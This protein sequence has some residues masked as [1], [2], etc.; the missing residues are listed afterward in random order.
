MQAANTRQRHTTKKKWKWQLSS[1]TKS[2][3]DF[4]SHVVQTQATHTWTYSYTDTHEHVRTCRPSTQITWGIE[5]MAMSRTFTSITLLQCCFNS[6]VLEHKRWPSL[7]TQRQQ[8]STQEEWPYSPTQMVNKRGVQTQF[9]DGYQVIYNLYISP[10]SV[11]CRQ[12]QRRIG[13]V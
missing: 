9:R 12:L 7:P 2:P 6:P 3:Y 10:A 4:F 11:F 8:S 13:F 5:H 1:L